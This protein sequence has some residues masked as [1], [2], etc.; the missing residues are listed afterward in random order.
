MVTATGAEYHLVGAHVLTDAGRPVRID[1]IAHQLANI[2]RFHGATTR[3]YSVAEHSLLCS[4]IAQRAMAKPIT[5]LAALL[6]D[7]HEIY[8]NDLS[9]P[10]KRAVN[11]RSIAAGGT[12]A[13]DV[14][15]DE[16]A[17]TVRAHFGVSSVSRTMHTALRTIDLV[18]LATERRDLLPWRAETHQPWAVL[19]D[20]HDGAIEPLCWM[21]LDTPEREAMTWRD[22]RQQFRD[23]FDELVFRLELDTPRRAA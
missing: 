7:A 18:A 17:R 9:S 1:D 19:G 15:E 12:R 14:F 2:N 8:T 13:W 4:E 3:P 10:A 20:E 5:Q 22:W 23:R 21:R 16:H 11:F 6:H